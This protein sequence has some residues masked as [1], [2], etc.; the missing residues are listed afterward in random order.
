MSTASVAT[1]PSE[2]SAWD[3]SSSR[4]S[5][6]RSEHETLIDTARIIGDIRQGRRKYDPASISRETGLSVD[7]IEGI[8]RL[9]LNDVSSTNAGGSDLVSASPPT[10]TLNSRT[11][12]GRSS[13]SP[14]SGKGVTWDE[15]S[16]RPDNNGVYGDDTHLQTRRRRGWKS[17]NTRSKYLSDKKA[18]GKKMTKNEDVESTLAEGLRS[19]VQTVTNGD[20]WD[21]VPTSQ[22]T[23][24]DDFPMLYKYGTDVEALSGLGLS[25][26]DRARWEEQDDKRMKLKLRPIGAPLSGSHV[27]VGIKGPVSTTGSRAEALAMGGEEHSRWAD[28]AYGL[29]DTFQSVILNTKGDLQKYLNLGNGDAFPTSIVTRTRDMDSLRSD[30]TSTRAAKVERKKKNRVK[31][32][33]PTQHSDIAYRSALTSAMRDELKLRKASESGDPDLQ[34]RAWRD[35]ITSLQVKGTLVDSEIATLYDT[36]AESPNYDYMMGLHGE[37]KEYQ[38]RWMGQVQQ[39]NKSGH[40]WVQALTEEGSRFRPEQSNTEDSSLDSDS[41]SS[42]GS[43]EGEQD[44]H[45]DWNW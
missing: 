12:R 37:D 44:V 27:G 45:S 16:F 40:K 6:T 38:R 24:Q 41:D 32:T 33:V 20:G 1:R 30:K 29:Q 34:R 43:E 17:L 42:D 25:K 21:F 22:L 19:R 18:R 7:T 10:T 39:M 14:N 3:R 23:L 13:R 9:I 31:T 26:K 36:L 28:M 11:R 5:G 4:V 35:H 15:S 2:R 8:R